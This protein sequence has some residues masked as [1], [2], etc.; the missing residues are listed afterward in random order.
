MSYKKILILHDYQKIGKGMI[1]AFPKDQYEVSVLTSGSPAGV[2]RSDL[3]SDAARVRKI[4]TDWGKDFVPEEDLFRERETE[5]V[6]NDEACLF[7]C[8][9][10]R[11]FFGLPVR[12]PSNQ[13]AYSNKIV[14]KSYLSK[15]GISVPTF[16]RI[17]WDLYDSRTLP[18]EVAKEFSFPL[19]VKPEE[20]GYNEGV[21][22]FKDKHELSHWAELHFG[23]PGW[24]LEAFVSGSLFHANSIILD[25]KTFPV[26]VGAYTSPPLGANFGRGFGS[27]TLPKEHRIHA[28]GTEL[29][30]KIAEILGKEGRFI[31]HTEF[32]VDRDQNATVIDVAARA[33][34]ALVSDIAEIHSKV[35]LEAANFRMQ[36]GEEP[37]LPRETGIF[38]GWFWS[39]PKKDGS[40]TSLTL[41]G[42]HFGDLLRDLRGIALGIGNL[43]SL[44][45]LEEL[46]EN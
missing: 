25:G 8:S 43:Q 1:S 6:T 13:I 2:F 37:C 46:Y 39:C 4:K 26:Q 21:E 11:R 18:L 12:S 16:K 42:D 32:F 40:V 31:L 33:P 14:M 45:W 17:D 22:I 34:G 27:V 44:P 10:L 38:A 28:I 15:A 23:E 19:V 41:W 9:R 30:A 24:Q 7:A 20:G 35:N 36:I 29:N 5:I 3:P